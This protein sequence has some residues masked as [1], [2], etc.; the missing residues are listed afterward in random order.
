MTSARRD[1][2][3]SRSVASHLVCD[4]FSVLTCREHESF[5]RTP[6]RH[7]GRAVAWDRPAV[8]PL[9]GFALRTLGFSG[10]RASVPISRGIAACAKELRLFAYEN[11]LDVLVM[12]DGGCSPTWIPTRRIREVDS[13]PC[14][15]WRR[16]G[17]RRAQGATLQDLLGPLLT[18]RGSRPPGTL[19]PGCPGCPAGSDEFARIGPMQTHGG[20]RPPG[21]EAGQADDLSRL[22]F[23]PPGQLR[24]C[25]I[26]CC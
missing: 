2:V 10:S 7:H 9:A 25:R 8:P 3:S 12:A 20:S 18:H 13:P 4:G 24:V 11:A 23:E 19:N 15:A 6:R 26:G 5:K 14:S 17:P 1:V 22:L 21:T 16:A